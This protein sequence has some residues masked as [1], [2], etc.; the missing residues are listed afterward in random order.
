METVTPFLMFQGDA[1]AAAAFYAE[2]FHDAKIIE[3][4]RWAAGEAGPEG[5]F[6][7]A[8]L[9]LAGQTVTCFDSPVKHAFGFTPAFSLFAT[10]STREEFDRLEATLGAGGSAL[11]PPDDYGFSR[12]YAWINDRFGVSWQLNLP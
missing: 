10:C 6:K 8:R 9:S 12:R 1:E 11:M 7:L 5:A 3:T 4:E 2:V